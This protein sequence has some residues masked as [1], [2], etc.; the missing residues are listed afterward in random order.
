M[1]S[2][3]KLENNTILKPHKHKKEEHLYPIA[4]T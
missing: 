1:N 3:K 4:A 2:E